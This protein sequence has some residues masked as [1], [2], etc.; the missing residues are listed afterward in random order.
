M[1]STLSPVGF[2]FGNWSGARNSNPGPHGP[3]P[4]VSDS[5]LPRPVTSAD[6]RVCARPWRESAPTVITLTRWPTDTA[7]SER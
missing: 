7:K 1:S 5:V 4:C 6:A 3:D 2:E